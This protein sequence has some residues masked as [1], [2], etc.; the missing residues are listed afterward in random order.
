MNEIGI[1]HI[2]IEQRSGIV[3]GTKAKSSTVSHFSAV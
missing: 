3:G 1:L 2:G